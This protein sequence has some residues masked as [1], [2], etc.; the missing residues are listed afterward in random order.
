MRRSQALLCESDGTL[1]KLLRPLFEEKGW[2]LRE[3]RQ[4]ESMK[5]TLQEGVPVVI[6]KLGRR[7]F[8]ELALLEQT[9]W[10]YPETAMV[11]I[12]DLANPDLAALCWDLGARFV[13]FPPWPREHLR[14][15]VKSL[16]E[17]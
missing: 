14:D 6:L 15:I 7:L 16:M 8:E 17:N 1:A 4:I 3:F 13:L 2:R 10:A 5:T 12:G 11:V 9:H